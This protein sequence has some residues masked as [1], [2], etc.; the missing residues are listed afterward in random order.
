MYNVLKTPIFGIVLT[1]L[2]FNIGF[3][4]KNKSYYRLA[5]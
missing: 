4:I 3:Y 2:F 1:I 5:Y